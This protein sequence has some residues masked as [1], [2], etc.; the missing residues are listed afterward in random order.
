[1]V[2]NMAESQTREQHRKE[3][4]ERLSEIRAE[5]ADQNDFREFAAS[6]DH[7]YRMSDARLKA[8][9]IERTELKEILGDL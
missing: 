7:H 2:S 1:M 6:K 9:R 3:V 8:L 5:I 4:L